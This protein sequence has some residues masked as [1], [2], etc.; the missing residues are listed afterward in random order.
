MIYNVWSNSY[1]FRHFSV[2]FREVFNKAKY[3]NS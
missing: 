1:M 2:S 3:L